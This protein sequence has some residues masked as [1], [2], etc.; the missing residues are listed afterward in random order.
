MK[1]VKF[2]III[3]IAFIVTQNLFAQKKFTEGS[4]VYN[5]NIETT[6]GEKQLSSA[7]NGAVLTIFLTN[8][9]SKTELVSTPG[10][11][12]TVYDNTAKKGFI[13]KEYS[14]QKLMITTTAENWMLK[15]Q[16]NNNLAF[17]IGSS[18]ET[19]A[20]HLCKKATATSVDGKL[21]TVY[22][23][24]T[25][26]VTNKLYNNAFSSIPGLPI[27]YQLQSGNIV[28]KYVLSKFVTESIANN[29]FDAPKSSFRVMTFEENQQL[30]KGE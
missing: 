30:K 29:V 16:T 19:I 24:P 22:F 26:L 1:Y 14:G 5:I 13:L 10:V 18:T 21:Y 3:C 25:I 9:K 8:D 2:Y 23:D 20:G 17:S 7:L 15:N 27:Q 4:L 12:T 28:F 6:K 11:E